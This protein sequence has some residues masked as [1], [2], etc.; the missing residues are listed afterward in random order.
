[1]TERVKFPEFELVGPK[2]KEPGCDGVLVFTMDKQLRH[3][4]HQCSKCNKK[5]GMNKNDD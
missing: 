3:C 1:M 4:W 2:C 5:F